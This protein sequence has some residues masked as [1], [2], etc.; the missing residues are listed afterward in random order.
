MS[1]LGGMNMTAAVE[2]LLQRI[3]SNLYSACGSSIYDAWNDELYRA[4][5]QVIRE[6]IGKNWHRTMQ[7]QREGKRIYF[8]SFEYMPGKLL[9]KNAESCGLYE[10]LKQALHRVGRRFS[11]L[12]EIEREI[13]LGNGALGTITSDELTTAAGMGINAMGYGLRYKN[14]RLKQTLVDGAQVEKPDNWTSNKNPWEHDRPFFHTIPLYGGAVKA[15]PY[16][17]PIPGYSGNTVNTLRIWRAEALEDIDFQVFSRGDFSFAYQTINRAHAIVEFLYPDETSKKGKMLRLMQEYFYASATIQDILRNFH[18]GGKVRV[19]EELPKYA[20]IQ[21]NDV[22]AAFAIPEFIR[23]IMEHYA[24]TFDQARALAEQI[25]HYTNFSTQSESFETWSKEELEEVCPQLI[26][27]FEQLEAFYQKEMASKLPHSA[28]AEQREAAQRSLSLYDGARVD[29]VNMALQVAHRFI[30]LSK[31]HYDALQQMV[32]ET[33]RP[34]FFEKMMHIRMGV[35]PEHWFQRTNP[36]LYRYVRELCSIDLSG[37]DDAQAMRELLNYVD[38][39]EVLRAVGQI[40]QAHKTDI[41]QWI[42]KEKGLVINRFSIYDMQLGAF[43]EAKRQL[44]HALALAAK[45]FYLIDH[46]NADVPEVTTFFSGKA[47]PNYYAAKETLHFINALAESINK[48]HGIKDKMKV[49]FVEN[50]NRSLLQKLLPACDIYENLGF[51]DREPCGTTGIK[52]MMNGALNCTSRAGLGVDFVEHLP[53]EACY[54][55]GR[56]VAENQRRLHQ[57]NRVERLFAEQPAVRETL[58]RLLNSSSDFLRYD[59]HRL[60]DLLL[61]YDDSF[62][63]LEELPDYIDVKRQMEQDFFAERTWN[64]RSLQNIAHSGAFSMKMTLLGY[65]EGVWELPIYEQRARI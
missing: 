9:R 47:A 38:D 21:I 54:P 11:A 7:T 4:V 60:Y 15:I 40:K 59:F 2:E 36:P 25:F 41:Q 30:A 63:V 6:Q 12:E 8:L 55:F 31:S 43:H 35:S 13:S 44:M 26:P 62:F 17:I 56:S 57:P 16:D 64:R 34:I 51:A 49:V 58:N 28:A 46:P 37:E 19:I 5:C 18:K 52:A 33:A 29:T 39:D 20:A 1:V 48:N 14:G 45:Y 32:D 10:T 53:K 23:C 61:R 50:Y 27:I 22:Q 65:G 3:E 24:R 42:Q